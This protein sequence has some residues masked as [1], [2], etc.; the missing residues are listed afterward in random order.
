MINH[1]L[2]SHSRQNQAKLA[3]ELKDLG[4]EIK[5][6]KDAFRRGKGREDMENSPMNR[7]ERKSLIYIED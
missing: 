7:S 3:K 6:G 5:V 2:K 4:V 1:L